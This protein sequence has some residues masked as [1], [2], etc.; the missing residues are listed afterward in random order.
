MQRVA[1]R[2]GVVLAT[3]VDADVAAQVQQL[4][5]EAQIKEKARIMVYK[6]P[7]VRQEKLPGAVAMITAGSANEA[8]VE[9]CRVMLQSLGCY[10]FT[11]GQ[12]GIMGMH[13]MVQNIEA[14]RAADVVIVVT[15]A[16][17]SMVSMVAGMVDIPVIALPTSSGYGAAFAGVAPLL[18]SLNSSAPGVT[19]VNIDSGCGAS[20]A[21]WRILKN[22]AKFRRVAAASN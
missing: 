22:A 9:E 18:G 15:G 1:T 7:T 20:M 17:G 6:S 21:A 4:L 8:V 5:P 10:C 2:Q 14:V 11:L 16:D 19:V 13:R 12:A 3:L